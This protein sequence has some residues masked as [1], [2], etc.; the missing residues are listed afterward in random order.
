MGCNGCGGGGAA[1]P[2]GAPAPTASDSVSVIAA[3]SSA[4]VM[5]HTSS[6]VERLC[7]HCEGRKPLCILALILLGYIIRGN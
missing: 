3:E 5:E 7:K 1:A 2:I 6:L 4:S